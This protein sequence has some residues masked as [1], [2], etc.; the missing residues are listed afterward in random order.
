MENP[1]TPLFISGI[2]TISLYVLV[3]ATSLLKL[4]AARNSPSGLNIFTLSAVLVHGLFLYL[5]I[6]QTERQNLTLFNM[7]SLT[8]WLAMIVLL[9]NSFKRNVTLMTSIIASFALLSSALG[10]AYP[11]EPEAQLS[12][13]WITLLHIFS[14][15]TATGF[16][17]LAAVQA[18][19]LAFAD[20]RLKSHPTHVPSYFP[21]LQS[22]ESFLFQ[23]LLIGFILMSLSLV[24]AIFFLQEGFSNQP[25]HK[26]VLST[27][28]WFTFGILL[29]GHQWKGWRGMTAAKWTLAG[30][31]LL[32][33][34]YFGSKLVIEL[35][36]Q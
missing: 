21:P 4:R 15:I 29:V 36:L 33:L 24:I 31:V 17:L 7:M 27:L 3:V 2:F 6:D 13:Q 14:A 35:I 20:M 19:L 11:G 25:L 34:G 30:F 8:N 18:I 9:I 26:S 32:S 22:L 28:A 1:L 10:M 12:G 23:W 16:L 5:L